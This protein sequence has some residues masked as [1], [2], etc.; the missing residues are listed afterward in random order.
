MK[1]KALLLATGVLCI[2]VNKR[3]FFWKQVNNSVVKPVFL[4]K[5]Q[6]RNSL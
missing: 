5:G 3:G 4:L 2:E 6:N 1:R